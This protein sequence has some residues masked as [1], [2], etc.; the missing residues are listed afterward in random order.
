MVKLTRFTM[1]IFAGNAAQT[2]TSVF[3]TMKTSPQ[4][5]SDVA[6]SIGTTAYG[7]GWAD[8]IEIGYAPY[9]EDMN[10]VQRAI[11][12]QIAYN[13]QEGIPEWASD[14]TYFKGSWAKYNATNGAQIYESLVDNNTGN[15]VS[16]TTK[17]KLVYDTANSAI[18]SIVGSNLTASRALVSNSSGKVAV[19]AVT[20][21]E[22]GY[23]D[24]V[25]SAIQTQ[26]NAKA[27][28]NA[29]VKL[30]GNQTIGGT[31]TFSSTISGSI[32]GNAATVTNGVYTTGDQEISGTKTFKAS[33]AVNI[34]Q[35]K[36]RLQSSTI[37]KGTEPASDTELGWYNFED[38]AGRSMGR[39]R[40]YY[41]RDKSSVIQMTA[42]QANSSGDS[43]SASIRVVY[44]ASGGAYATAPA[45]SAA[46]SIVTTVSATKNTRGAFSY[47]NGMIVNF[48]SSTTD[49]ASGTT[50]TFREP[51][52]SATSYGVACTGTNS[53][54]YLDT[55]F[56]T[57]TNFKILSNAS[58]KRTYVA[59]G[60]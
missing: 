57:A 28:D 37:T 40:Y 8:A 58:G 1:P 18:T 23:L 33:P 54:Q 5:T 52:T 7:N 50:F 51:F 15:L 44:P 60:Y 17:W 16:D 39:L 49:E 34:S 24:G 25:T 41:N 55:S 36:F 27:A 19:S 59:I 38:N 10:T 30:T 43:N 13:Q 9:L 6:A 4:Y 42:Y 12:Y 22:L 53:G 48:Y 26:I 3:G 20:A 35:P 21:T 31:K 11:T 32:N 46:D 29:V 14:T 47:G 45:S 2:Q 56:K